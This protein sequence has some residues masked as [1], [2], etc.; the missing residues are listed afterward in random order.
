MSPASSTSAPK[1]G[2]S[3]R[4]GVQQIDLRE[5]DLD[6]VGRRVDA[7]RRFAEHVDVGRQHA[8]RAGLHGRDRH[9]ARTAGEVDHPL[10]RDDLGIVEDVA[11]Q[12]LA[13]G[14]GEGP[15]RRRQA[16]LGQG[17]FGQLPDRR[18]LVGEVQLEFGRVGRG[19]KPGV[20]EDEGAA[21][22]EGG[23]DHAPLEHRGGLGARLYAGALLDAAFSTDR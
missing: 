8:G 2:G 9:Q 15:E 14:P 21:A 20:L 11:R 23:F 22:G 6:P 18:D 13:A 1:G 4:R 7:D 16:D 12:G 5:R 3:R 10:A 17:L 19:L